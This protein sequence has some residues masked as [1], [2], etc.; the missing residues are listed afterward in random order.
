MMLLV[1]EGV[2]EVAGLV[3]FLLIVS[4]LV[5]VLAGEFVFV[6]LAASVLVGVVAGEFVFVPLAASVLVGVVAG[7]FV[8]VP[9]FVEDNCTVGMG[10]SAGLLSNVTP[11]KKKDICL[12]F[13]SIKGG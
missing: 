3:P 9:L 12:V 5:G 10:F 1:V 7:E 8:F 6:P 13:A 2:L 11:F 4:A